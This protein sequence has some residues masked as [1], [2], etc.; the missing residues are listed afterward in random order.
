MT[1]PTISSMEKRGGLM[2][3]ERDLR[4]KP[5]LRFSVWTRYGLGDVMEAGNLPRDEA[6]LSLVINT[7]SCRF[8]TKIWT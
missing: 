6:L 1:M 5:A 3:T 2:R 7:I 4:L 8:W